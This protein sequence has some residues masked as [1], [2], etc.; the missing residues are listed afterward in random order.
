M[1]EATLISLANKHNIISNPIPLDNDGK[2]GIIGREDLILILASNIYK[3]I[4][5]Q[6]SHKVSALALIMNQNLDFLRM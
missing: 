3:D 6:A 5:E 2:K 1:Y 4:L